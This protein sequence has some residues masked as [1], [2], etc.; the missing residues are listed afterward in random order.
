MRK[1]TN[2][3]FWDKIT[4]A[5]SFIDLIGNKLKKQ[6]LILSNSKDI[7]WYNYFRDQ[8]S[9]I[10]KKYNKSSMYI[11]DGKKYKDIFEYEYEFNDYLLKEY[12]SSDLQLQC[13]SSVKLSEFMA[14]NDDGIS[15]HKKYIWIDVYSQKSFENWVN[16]IS[17]YVK[18]RE[19]HLEGK[20]NKEIACFL[21]SC[22]ENYI[23]DK[24]ESYSF[25]NYINSYDC[26][27]LFNLTLSNFK[28]LSDFDLKENIEEAEK[29]IKTYIAEFASNIIKDKLTEKNIEIFTQ[30]LTKEFY[31]KFLYNPYNYIINRNIES[32]TIK[33]SL[34]KSQLKVIFPI[35]EEFRQKVVDKYSELIKDFIP[36]LNDLRQKKAGNRPYTP[37]VEVIDCEVKDFI[38]LL[39]LCNSKSNSV[40]YSK[41]NEIVQLEKKTN[42]FIKD[43][44]ENYMEE[45][46]Q[47]II[48]RYLEIIEE[49]I[50]KLNKNR[51]K[52]AWKLNRKYMPIK[53][54]LTDW[55][56]KEFMELKDL[57]KTCIDKSN[58]VL[59]LEK[60]IKLFLSINLK[61]DND[62]F[63]LFYDYV[64]IRNILAHGN[65]DELLSFA[66]VKH[67]IYSIRMIPIEVMM[68]YCEKYR[69][70]KKLGLL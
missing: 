12:C 22:Q 38:E 47:E 34:L 37:I 3:I 65:R 19:K 7:P 61:K 59:K 24:L 9:K 56:F 58:K 30:C 70:C 43:I 6:S 28:I 11:I 35:L 45:L 69:I 55:N 49:F 27:L 10:I 18:Y 23:S 8:I 54:D 20:D 39:K 5:T 53:E 52:Q 14:E 50:P 67:V 26:F 33:R 31:K 57:L 51:Q 13:D 16:F 60:R 29:D 41:Y 63:N 64:E 44:Y 1:N 42:N 2:N 15:I 62:I 4:N 21:I 40:E 46:R 36:Q 25:G 68:Y 66:E 17:E 32:Y 48:E